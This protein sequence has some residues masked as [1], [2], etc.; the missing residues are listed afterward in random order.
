MTSK[1]DNINQK[2]GLKIR[3]E[4]AKRN[5]SQEKLAEISDMSK[6]FIGDIERGK[7]SPT[8]ETLVKIANA[9]EIELHD[10]T[11]VSKVDI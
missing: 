1:V 7:S 8:I 2:I 9:F 3:L 5:W 10:L 4:R 6:T 11:N